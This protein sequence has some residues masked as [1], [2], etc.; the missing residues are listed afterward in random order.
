MSAVIRVWWVFF[1]A[2]PVQRWLAVGGL[3]LLGLGIAATLLADGRLAVSLG[4]PPGA[5]GRFALTLGL[6]AFAVLALFPA[7]FASGGILR[8][9]AA[10]L[11]HQL[12]PLFRLRLLLAMALFLVILVAPVGALFWLRPALP[13]SALPIAAMTI[14]FGVLTAI[15]LTMFAAAAQWGWM[16]LQF[17]VY[18]A[19]ALWVGSGGPERLAAA[20]ISLPGLV[21]AAAAGGWLI[22]V[23]WFLRARRIRP[24]MLLANAG[25]W[26][27]RRFA[28]G[29]MPTRATAARTLVRG[30]L[31]KPL[32]Q[33]LAW[34]VV[35]GVTLCLGLELLA[36]LPRQ[37]PPPPSPPPELMAFIW[38]FWAMTGMAATTGVLVRQ[39]RLLWLFVPG[40]RADVLRVV[41]ATMARGYLWAA[42]IIATTIAMAVALEWL[43]PREIGWAAALLLSAALYG[44]YVGLTTMRGYLLPIAGCLAMALLQVAILRTGGGASASA[45]AAMIA[46]HVL[47]ACLFRYLATRRWRSIDWLQVQPIRQTRL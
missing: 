46:A 41:E 7:V 43:A 30:R 21:G 28:D 35:M 15:V 33:E 40:S 8:A 12:L 26:P 29:E 39:S 3:C 44:C 11:S 4:L 18:I 31:A 10:P 2:F 14:V 37:V 13:D 47:G 23:I 16:M 42:T 17:P 36:L 24:P 27:S 20:G 45:L 34:A 25:V 5:E 32:V 19:G 1:T 38:P 6:I 9:L 22:F